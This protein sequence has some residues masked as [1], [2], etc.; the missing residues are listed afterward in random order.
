MIAAVVN[1]TGP[2][3]RPLYPRAIEKL[4]GTADPVAVLR[5]ALSAQ[6]DQSAVMFLAGPRSTFSA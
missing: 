4:N 2:D 1:R 5:N 6:Q 3:G